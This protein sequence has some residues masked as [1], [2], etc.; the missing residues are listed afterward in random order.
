MHRAA[1]AWRDVGGGKYHASC[2]RAR[3]R[4]CKAGGNGGAIGDRH[5][6]CRVDVDERA[7]GWA[8]WG[9]GLCSVI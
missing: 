3:D 4:S 6:I 7:G 5:L 1:S 9:E 8:E 2:R